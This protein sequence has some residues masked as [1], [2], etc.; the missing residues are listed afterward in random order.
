MNGLRNVMPPERLNLAL[1]WLEERGYP[2]ARA[3]ADWFQTEVGPICEVA[4][5]CTLLDPPKVTFFG[6]GS[7][8]LTWCPME[9]VLAQRVDYVEPVPEVAP[10]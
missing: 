6:L 7:T 2:D 3:K 1:Q 9:R 8:V 4:F 5:E 10:W